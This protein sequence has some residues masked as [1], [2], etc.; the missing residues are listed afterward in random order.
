MIDALIWPDHARDSASKDLYEPVIRQR[1]RYTL[2]K[3]AE[4]GAEPI[5]S[6]IKHTLVPGLLTPI[7]LRV[8]RRSVSRPP[9]S[10]QD[11]VVLTA[12]LCLKSQCAQ[13]IPKFCLRRKDGP[14]RVADSRVSASDSAAADHETSR[15]PP[16]A[17]PAH[18]VAPDV[19]SPRPVTMRGALV[20][21]SHNPVSAHVDTSNGDGLPL[22]HASKDNLGQLHLCWELKREPVDCPVG[23]LID[24]V[25]PYWHEEN[26]VPQQGAQHLQSI[27]ISS[28]P[29]VLPERGQVDPS[30]HGVRVA[31]DMVQQPG[32]HLIM[33]GNSQFRHVKLLDAPPTQEYHSC[34]DR[35]RCE[36]PDEPLVKFH[37]P[38]HKRRHR[39]PIRTRYGP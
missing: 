4:S 32:P 19:V 14:A 33:L 31:P 17:I 3:T 38:E 23:Q 30:A 15:I 29:L 35:R 5:A 7:G 21:V 34:A 26:D 20:E 11:R 22:I 1:S 13:G 39:Q 28:H 24:P 18:V 37:A 6:S 2:S 8:R 25:R 9:E 10:D 12:R 36:Y 16:S 27:T